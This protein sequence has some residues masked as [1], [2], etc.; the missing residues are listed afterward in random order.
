MRRVGVAETELYGLD[1]EGGFVGDLEGEFGGALV[2]GFLGHESH[3]LVEG[4]FA[5]DPCVHGPV[6]FVEFAIEFSVQS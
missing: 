6:L 3:R 1:L 4:A 2:V 5:D